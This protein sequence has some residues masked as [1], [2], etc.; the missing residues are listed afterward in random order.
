M[1]GV[2]LTNISYENLVANVCIDNAVLS[3][4]NGNSLV[5]AVGECITLSSD[6][7]VIPVYMKN[8]QPISL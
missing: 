1:G 2:V 5:T 6:T 8:L 7:G 4:I 3:G